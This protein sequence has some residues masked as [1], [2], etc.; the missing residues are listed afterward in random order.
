MAPKKSSPAKKAAKKPCPEGQRRNRETGR[1]R[2]I[3]QKK[4]EKKP[5][6]EGQRRN[7]ETGRCRAIAQKKAEKK[8]CNENQRRNPATGRCKKLPCKDGQRYSPVAGK[9]VNIELP[10]KRSFKIVMDSVKPSVKSKKGVLA[11]DG[12]RYIAKNP[13]EAAR[14]AYSH[15]CR[16][17]PKSNL[18]KITF[19]IRET[20]QGSGKLVHSYSGKRVKL[21]KPVL[22]ERAGSLPYSVA[23]KSEVVALK[24]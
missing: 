17:R 21:A 3:A 20:T 6:P 19:D 8:P 5:C 9:C 2:A 11:E 18:C 14:R 15:L 7:R 10:E 13:T 4:A 12:G 16:A 23:Y 24:K 22:I 1:C